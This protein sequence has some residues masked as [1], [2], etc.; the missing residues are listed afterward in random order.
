LAPLVVAGNS[1]YF[2]GYPD[3]LQIY[4]VSFSSLLRNSL[5]WAGELSYR[6]NAPLQLSTVD[7]LSAVQTPLDDNQSPLQLA[8]GQS[9]SGY[10]RKDI[11]QLQTSLSQTFDQVMGAQQFTVQGE[12]ALVQVSGLESRSDARYG[13]DPVYG[14]GELS[15]NTCVTRNTDALNAAGAPLNNASRYC[16]GDGFVTSTAWGYR[17]RAIWEYQQVLPKLILKPNLAWAQDVAGYGPNQL[18]SEGSK[19]ASIGLDAEYQNIYRASLNYSSFFDGDFN[20]QSDRDFLLFSLG[21]NF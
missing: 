9:L 15:G 6:P 13:R 4:A 18:F 2:M 20:T 5:V 8:P 7:L 11:S 12:V 14:P 16:S 1:Q 17:T 10:R 21:L 19:A 3:D